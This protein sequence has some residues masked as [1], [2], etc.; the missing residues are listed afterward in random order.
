MTAEQSIEAFMGR[1]WTTVT[2]H[3][4]REAGRP[5]PDDFRRPLPRQAMFTAFETEL[6]PVPAS[7]DALDAI[8]A[9]E[10]RRLERPRS[11]RS[12]GTLGHTG[13]SGADFD[14]PA[15]SAPPRSSTASPRPTCSCT[16][17]PR[18][19]GS[20]PTAPWWRTHRAGVAGRARRR[21]DAVRLRRDDAR[22]AARGRAAC[23]PTWPSCRRCF[24]RPR[25]PARA[26]PRRRPACRRPRARRS[27]RARAARRPGSARR[28]RPWPSCAPC[29]RPGA[30][31]GSAPC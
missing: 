16:P 28:S 9:A 19:A 4:R 14:G 25:R 1:R 11:R 8:D 15:S 26:T 24:S 31:R 27:A 20:P 18:W 17:P 29:R 30:G 22:R 7:R 2:A 3:V 10:L 21:D 13:L 5:L 6:A 12:A 23:S